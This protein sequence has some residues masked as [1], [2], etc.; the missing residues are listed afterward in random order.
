M[1]VGIFVEVILRDISPPSSVLMRNYK[2]C[3]LHNVCICPRTFLQAFTFIQHS[4]KR[5]SLITYVGS[6][7]GG[8]SLLCHRSKRLHY[9][10]LAQTLLCHDS[11]L[12]IARR[13]SKEN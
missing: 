8:A 1:R 3:L 6:S 13:V 9:E 7:Q 5:N 4:Q 12:C 10:T 11:T 2:I